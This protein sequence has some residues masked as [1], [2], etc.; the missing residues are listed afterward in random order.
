MKFQASEMVESPDVELVSRSLETNLRAQWDEVAREGDTIVL[1]GLG[2]THRVNRND[3]AVFSVKASDGGRTAIEVEATYLASALVGTG[4]PQNEIVQRK[5]DGVLELVR[6]DVDLAQRR[7]ALEKASGRKPVLVSRN[8]A[9]SAASPVVASSAVEAAAATTVVEHRVQTRFG[10][11][12]ETT[13]PAIR[14]D[15]GVELTVAS[16]HIDEKAEPV[17]PS[18]ETLQKVL[19]RMAQREGTK[20]TIVDEPDSDVETDVFS[21]HRADVIARHKAA[22]QAA[23]L[24]MAAL[25]TRRL[26]VDEASAS[27]DSNL[28]VEE[29]GLVHRGRVAERAAGSKHGKERSVALIFVVLLV[30]FLLAFVAQMGWEYRADVGQRLATWRATWSGERVEQ[31]QRGLSELTPEQLA[32]QQQAERAAAAADAEHAAEATRLAEPDPKQ[33]L[34]NWA[35]T[36]KGTDAGAQAAY[37]ADQVNKYFLRLNVSRAEVMAARQDEITRRKGTWT[38]RLDDVVVAQQT[39]TAARILFVKYIASD[40]GSGVVE[41]RLPT[42]IKLKRID[43]QWRIVSEQTLG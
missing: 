42:Q 18:G 37:Y 14:E 6:M 15:S 3:R 26:I 8:A 34:E 5:L 33:W 1:R 10:H 13:L 9:S 16:E 7:A 31:S 22:M 32:A 17:P 28:R 27:T 39:D 11:P 2:P 4:A 35:D 30:T 36:M 40:D 19:E 21:P 23:E 12:D 25:S 43:G 20:P 38:M 41:Q 24:E 29:Q